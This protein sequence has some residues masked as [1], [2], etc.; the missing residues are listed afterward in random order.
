MERRQSI[1]FFISVVGRAVTK[2]FNFGNK[3]VIAEEHTSKVRSKIMGII[4][5]DNGRVVSVM[6]SEAISDIS[7]VVT[8]SDISSSPI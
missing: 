1:P 8:R 4:A 3:T 6:G 7:R 5:W 2:F